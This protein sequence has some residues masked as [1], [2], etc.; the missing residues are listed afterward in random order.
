[1]AASKIWSVRNTDGEIKYVEAPDIDC[2]AHVSACMFGWLD[3]IARYVITTSEPKKTIKRLE[4]ERARGVV[5]D[6]K[7]RSA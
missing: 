6:L 2:A 7:R 5:D 4:M 3:V 1:M